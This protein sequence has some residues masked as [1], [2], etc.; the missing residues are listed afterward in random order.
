MKTRYILF[1]FAALA[2]ASCSKDAAQS[3]TSGRQV[4]ITASLE[5][6]PDTRAAVQDGGRQVFW[7]P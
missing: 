5:E 4:V 3:T 2:A 6:A 7:E 1:A